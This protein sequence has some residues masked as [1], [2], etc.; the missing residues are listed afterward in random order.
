MNIEL[1]HG[2]CLEEMDYI[3]T[4]SIDMVMVDV[5]YGVTHCKWDSIIPLEPMWELL[6]RIVKPNRAMVFTA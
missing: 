2:D 6:H 3:L 4:D 5:P 1:I